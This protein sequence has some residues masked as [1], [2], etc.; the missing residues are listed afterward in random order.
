MFIHMVLFKIRALHV[1]IYRADCR[2][3]EKEARRHPGF[4]GYHTL[5]RTNRKGEYA[6]FYLWDRE[7]SHSRFMKKH[8]DRLVSL[9]HCPVTVLGY[10]NFKTL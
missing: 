3:W 10:Y 5:V 1:R 2:L 7:T 9:S 6:S 8:H 4:L